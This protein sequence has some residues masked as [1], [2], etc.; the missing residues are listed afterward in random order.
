LWQES[1]E[2][3]R[4]KFVAVIKGDL[5]SHKVKFTEEEINKT[6]QGLLLGSIGSAAPLIVPAI[7]AVMLQR[8]TQGFMAWFAVTVLGQRAAQ[9]AVLGA[10]AG[11]WGWAISGGALG[12]GVITSALKYRGERK[13]L[14]FVQAILS[15]Y[16]YRYQNRIRNRRKGVTK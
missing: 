8:L 15:I 5:E 16:A 12:V 3:D 13:K 6:L 7:S 4:Q 1:S 9:I 2:K 10:L 14:R 11:P